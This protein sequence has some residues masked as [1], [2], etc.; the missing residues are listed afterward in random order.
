MV[1]LKNY[2]LSDN[3]IE[4]GVLLYFDFRKKIGIGYLLNDDYL[5]YKH[6]RYFRIAKD[7]ELLVGMLPLLEINVLEMKSSI[8]RSRF[9]F[10]NVVPVEKLL[11]TA[12]EENFSLYWK[13]LALNWIEQLN[14]NFPTIISVLF[15]KSSANSNLPKD[16][17]FKI[18]RLMKKMNGSG[19]GNV[20]N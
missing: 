18:K 17:K 14:C 11:L 15:E 12:F 19:E 13:N 20:S 9:S 6:S 10:Y 1:E 7:K 4:K 16:F 8:E 3:S 5:L 2:L